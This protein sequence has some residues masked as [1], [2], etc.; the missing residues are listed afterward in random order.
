MDGIKLT[1]ELLTIRE[2]A[3]ILKVSERTIRRWVASG[4]L[5]YT[6]VGRRVYTTIDSLELLSKR[7]RQI[8]AGAQQ[9]HDELIDFLGG[10]HGLVHT[11][12]RFGSEFRS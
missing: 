5:D 2:A 7:P 1:D 4:R 8:S 6:K 11:T 10:T 3:N 12:A 9:A